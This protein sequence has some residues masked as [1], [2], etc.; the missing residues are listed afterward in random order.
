[1]KR[2]HLPL[3]VNA[4]V[5]DEW[6]SA[7]IIKFRVDKG[8]CGNAD[9]V[10]FRGVGWVRLEL[11]FD[12]VFPL[13]RHYLLDTRLAETVPP[14]AEASLANALEGLVDKDASAEAACALDSFVEA[15]RIKASDLVANQ[16]LGVQ[17]SK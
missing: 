4:T 15:Y 6:F 5:L 3:E 14:P 1:M 8:L 7:S 2:L 17:V 10:F 11:R 13:S 16:V 12:K 9:D